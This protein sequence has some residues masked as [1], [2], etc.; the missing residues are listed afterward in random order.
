MI[1]ESDGL[2]L[3]DMIEQRFQTAPKNYFDKDD[4]CAEFK[5][6]KQGQKESTKDFLK[7]VEKKIAKLDLYDIHP[8]AAEQTVVL[9]EG[10]A[11]KH[12]VDPVVQLHTG[13][14]SIYSNW[15]KEGDLKHTLEKALQ[16]IKTTKRINEKIGGKKMDYKQ[17]VTSP[18]TGQQ[19]TTTSPPTTTL[20]PGTTTACDMGYTYM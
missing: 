3:W 15:I 20:T 11:S 2:R 19:G 14:N 17:A 18:P 7:C 12:L 4:L 13:Q 5:A 8:T 1:D 9:L 16:H 6:M 10:M